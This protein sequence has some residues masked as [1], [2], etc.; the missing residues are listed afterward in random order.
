MLR[1]MRA[2]VGLLASP[3][4]AA[5]VAVLLLNDRVLKYAVPGLVTGK[6]SDVAGLAMVGIVAVAV[7]GR[8]AIA[9][10]VTAGAW[11]A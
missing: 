6:L 9:L 3:L 2:R 10:T 11:I 1:A 7:C 5:T 8:P 4:F